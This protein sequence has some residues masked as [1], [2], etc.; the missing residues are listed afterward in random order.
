[1][2]NVFGISVSSIA[3]A[4]HGRK[5][6]LSETAAKVTCATAA[7]RL[8]PSLM[9]RATDPWLQLNPAQRGV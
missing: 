9:L 8:W 4:S 7:T 6:R 2:K 3:A 5:R 1:M